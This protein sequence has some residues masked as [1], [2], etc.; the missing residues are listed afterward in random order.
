MR[1]VRGMQKLI[2]K[3]QREIDFYSDESFSQG[4]GVTAPKARKRDK[5]KTKGF[6]F[7]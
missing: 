6:M 5:L 3:E 7:L 4:I 2:H 1:I